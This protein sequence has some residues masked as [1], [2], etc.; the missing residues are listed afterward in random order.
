MVVF[1]VSVT[2]WTT[3]SFFQRGDQWTVYKPNED[4]R[5]A[6]QVLGDELSQNRGP[7]V[8]FVTVPVLSLTYY[9]PRIGETG[10]VTNRAVGKLERI[11][12]L[13]GSTNAVG[14]RLAVEIQEYIRSSSAEIEMET[15]IAPDAATIHRDLQARRLASFYL[16]HDKFWSAGFRGRPGCPRSGSRR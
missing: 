10:G 14:R 16:V 8:A 11:Q 2:I 15:V 12:H 5:S 3:V 7:A 6:A 9:D 13:V 1:T 4:W